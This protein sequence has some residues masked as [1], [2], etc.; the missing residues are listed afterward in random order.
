MQDRRDRP[1]LGDGYS[2][3][4]QQPVRPGGSTELDLLLL[5]ARWPQRAED[6][7][8]IHET[9]ALPLDWERWLTLVEHHRL[10][11][12]VYRNLRGAL[13]EPGMVVPQQA[14]GKLKQFAELNAYRALRSLAELRRIVRE[15]QLRG[16]AVRVLKGLPLAQSI[17]G[18]LS[19]R[20]N[21]DLDLLIDPKDILQADQV[22]RGFGYTGLLPIGR[23]TPRQFSFYRAH[24]KDI[25]YARAANGS[26]VDLHWRC[27]RN[28]AMP[29][30]G[31]IDSDRRQA[32]SFGDFQ[33]E[34]LPPTET[35]LYLCVHGSLDGWIYLKSLADV[36]ALVRALTEAELDALA[37]TARGF[38][39]LPEL[40]AAALLV[41]RYLAMDNWSAHLLPE[42]DRTVAHILR[43]AD[44]CLVQ[45][46]FLSNREAVP[47][48]ATLEF[49]FG[50]R[51]G[52]R[53]R[54]ELLARILFRARMWETIPLPDL[55]FG[56]YPLLSPIEWAMFR[57]RQR[58]AK[59]LE[60]CPAGRVP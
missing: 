18:D 17:F 54:S 37:S 35:L 28:S 6:I 33:V 21:G 23:F 32:V 12:L 5:C 1:D 19:L 59:Q 39:I 49:E 25:S 11:P 2:T 27:F 55:L 46:Q 40:S 53:Y 42:N 38:G 29:G 16:V 43:Y 30:E 51:R 52:I 20:A 26:E 48:G 50:L 3:D 60:D 36:G 4:V 10:V 8:S 22:L 34:T 58:S 7:R 24:W 41:R 47:I 45:G 56:L 44:R 31:L 13:L 57:W 14:L 15:F 9:A